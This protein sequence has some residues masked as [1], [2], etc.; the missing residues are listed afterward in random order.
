MNHAIHISMPT[1]EDEMKAGELSG[2]SLGVVIE[3]MEDSERS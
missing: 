2:T 3:R 1:Y